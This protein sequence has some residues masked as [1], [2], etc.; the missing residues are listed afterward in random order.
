[1]SEI[2]DNQAVTTEMLNNIVNDLGIPEFNGFGENKFGVEALN[3]ITGDLTG[4]GILNINNK[5]ALNYTDGILTIDT[6]VIVFDD[7]AKL[8]IT[9]MKTFEIPSSESNTTPQ[10]TLCQDFWII[11]K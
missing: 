3:K 1:M 9:E 6:G 8:R 10:I 7:G 11:S 5:C 4:K 2:L